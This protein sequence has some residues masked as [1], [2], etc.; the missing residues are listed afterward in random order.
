[1]TM[2]E[3]QTKALAIA[4]EMMSYCPPHGIWGALV[5]ERCAALGA[6]HSYLLGDRHDKGQLQRAFKEGYIDA[7]IGYLDFLAEGLL[8]PR[9]RPSG[10]RSMDREWEFICQYTV[11][12]YGSHLLDPVRLEKAKEHSQEWVKKA[13]ETHLNL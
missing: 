13:L 5:I 4:L 9:K 7:D 12:G 11:Y 3:S 6:L 8:D 10:W 1:M 2:T